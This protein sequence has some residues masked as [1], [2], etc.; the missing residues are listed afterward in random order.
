M[1]WPVAVDY[2]IV[3]I[4]DLH[5][6]RVFLE[7]LLARLEA[8]PEWPRC[9]VVFLG[10]FVDRGPDVRGTIDLAMDLAARH[11]RVAA[12]MGNHDL[13]LVRAARLD[14]GPP[15]ASWIAGY[16]ERYD[17]G[18]TFLSYLGRLPNHDDWEGELEALR[19]AIPAPHRDF[20]ASLPWLV[21]APG[22]LFLHCGLSPEL[23]LTAEGQLAALRERRWDGTLRPRPGTMTAAL[24]QLD[25]P[26]WLGADRMLSNRPLALPGRVQVSGHVHLVAPEADAVRIR[27]D[28]SGGYHEPLT[29]CLLRSA[30]AEPVFITSR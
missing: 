6:Q 29:A 27:L 8:L 10:D 19:A 21:E 15:S 5:G 18:Q 13:A 4:A 20:L 22:H 24:W 1:T 12:V 16:R 25:Y 11:P 7:Q 2:P 17:H 26:V 23:D 28:T 3:A 9:T 14:G 30:D